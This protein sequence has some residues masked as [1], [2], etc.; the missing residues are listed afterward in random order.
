LYPIRQAEFQLVV[1]H[2]GQLLPYGL[3]LRQRDD[4]IGWVSYLVTDDG[5]LRQTSDPANIHAPLFPPFSYPTTRPPQ[6]GLNPWFVTMNTAVKFERFSDNYGLDKLPQVLR[7]IVEQTLKICDLIYQ[8][9]SPT[10]GYRDSLEPTR[11][12]SR[13]RKEVNYYEGNGSEE[14]SKRHDDEGISDMGL[15]F[16]GGKAAGETSTGEP[17]NYSNRTQFPVIYFI[18]RSI[19][20]KP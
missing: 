11:R 13:H 7:P 6:E 20:G 19:R 4:N 3:T 10:Q 15:P 5:L 17:M 18:S 12:S 8:D 14:D 9:V 1:L 16:I 2:P